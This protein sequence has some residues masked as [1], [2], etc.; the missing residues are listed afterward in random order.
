MYQ[1]IKKLGESI[2]GLYSLPTGKLLYLSILIPTVLIA[3][4]AVVVALTGGGHEF[5]EEAREIPMLGIL[6]AAVQTF[7]RIIIAYIFA[8]I[9]SVTL[10]I[11]T[12]RS[13]RTEKVLLPIIDILQSV[14]ILAFFP[15]L[16]FLFVQFGLFNLAAIVVFFF[17][18]LWM[19][20]FSLIGGLKIIP[21]E[22]LSMSKVFNFS[23]YQYI[24]HIII[25]AIT[26][27]LVTASILAWS[28]SWNI[29]IVAEVLHTYL[30]V[31]STVRDLPGIGSELV[32]AITD[33]NTY[34]FLAAVT[35]MIIFIAI[36][37]IFIWQNLLNY[38]QKFRF[39]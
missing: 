7:G 39:E 33:G 29:A 5:K 23:K 3:F 20:T 2:R 26:P 30:P 31:G 27:Q 22:I 35:V 8:V 32:K 4:F 14:P 15:I 12:V 19:M 13:P 11:F 25:P 1:K 24:R 38:A 21:R 17:T 28:Q 10:A 37:N 9:F 6:A 18:M 34:I 36:I 16:V